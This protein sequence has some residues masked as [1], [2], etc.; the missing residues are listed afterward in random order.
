M[1]KTINKLS[2]TKFIKR[3]INLKILKVLTIN[4][5]PAKILNVLILTGV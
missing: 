1:E 4:F 2:L 3:L 5:I